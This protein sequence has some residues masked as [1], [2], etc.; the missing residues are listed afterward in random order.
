MTDDVRIVIDYPPL[1][2]EIDAAFA[3][4][5]KPIIYAWGRTIYN[6]M[7]ILVTPALACHEGVHCGQQGDDIE[8]WWL[9]YIDD[10]EFRLAQEIEAH[11][12][13]YDWMVRS[14]TRFER[15]RAKKVV[16]GK[17]SSPVYGGLVTRAQAERLVVGKVAA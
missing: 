1:F 3:V 11:Q 14:G 4:R 8:G 10:P 7:N 5:G 15:R 13:E 12:A 16:A 9:R 2:D 17:L 6:P